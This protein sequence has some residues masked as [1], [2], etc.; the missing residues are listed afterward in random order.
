VGLGRRAVERVVMSAVNEAGGAAW[1]DRPVLVTGATGLLGGWVVEALLARRA[2]VVCLVRDRVPNSRLYGE[3]LDRRV[4]VVD[5]DV[6]DQ[7]VMERVLGEHEIR[8]V[9]HLAAQTI[10][11]I[12]NRNPVSTF[13]ANIR[14]TWS[15]L[16][17]VRRSPL[18]S[19]VVVASSDKAYG[20]QEVL[21]YA[22]GTPLQG[23][24]PYDVSKS[25]ADLIA[26][27]YAHTWQLPVCITRC[28]NF[29][30]GGDLN[31]NRLV[32]GTIRD[33]LHG[34]RPVVRSDGSLVRDYLYVEDGASAY[35][36]TAEA[37]MADPGR[38]GRAYNFSLE[39]PLTVLEMV[40]R[41]LDVLQSD[42]VPDVRDEATSEIKEQYL[43]STRARRELGW[44]PIVGLEDGLR[45][46]A[47]WYQAYFEG[48]R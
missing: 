29:Y 20:D 6:T 30:G 45:R 16:E 5:G 39:H 35:L 40:E 21:P 15:V 13:D 47:A 12:A 48:R 11:S 26:Q 24:H 22:E 46:T 9:L 1:A 2:M 37:L 14:G 25:C 43:D 3:A 34:R 18:V 42:L 10:V 8:T 19:E 32:P 7:A 27:A 28:G 41:L 17:A 4:I 33:V 36:R 23:R 44:V 31:F 38:A